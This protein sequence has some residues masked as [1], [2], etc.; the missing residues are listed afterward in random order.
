MYVESDVLKEIGFTDGEIRVYSA[1]LELGSTTSGRIVKKSGISS[2]K[3]YVILDKLANKGL[4]THVIRENRKYFQASSPRRIMELLKEKEQSVKAQKDMFSK[5]LPAMLLREK[6]GEKKHE[7]FV[8]EGYGGVKTYFQNLLKETRKGEE[9][10][11]FGAR[12]GYP[13]SKPAQ[14]FFSSYERKRVKAGARLKIIFNDDMR[15]SASIN[16]YREMP[17]T[18]V[19]FLPN[20]TMS[21]IGISRTGI[22]ILLWTKDTAVV[23]AIRSR[24]VA[25][26]FR[27]YFDV[28]WKTSSR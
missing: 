26:T 6:G 19:R 7:A 4:V 23:F 24:E 9:R 5:I 25:N 10:L 3:V 21:S 11:V 27:K 13:V 22:D 20:V 17:L 28:L 8:Y 15:G 14:R 16:M 12:T 1:L 2:S 18:K